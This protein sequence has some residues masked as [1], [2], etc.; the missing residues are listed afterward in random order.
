MFIRVHTA[1][2]LVD[3]EAPAGVHL[4]GTQKYGM[5]VISEVV[6][7]IYQLDHFHN[8][9]HIYAKKASVCECV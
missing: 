7:T 4:T 5:I 3:L 6:Y 2:R 1:G 9:Y 8:K